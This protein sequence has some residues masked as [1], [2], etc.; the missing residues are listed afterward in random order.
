MKNLLLLPLLLLT[1]TACKIDLSII[2]LGEV[3]TDSETIDCASG[4][5]G[6]CQQEYVTDLADCDD[7]AN[8]TLVDTSTTETFTALPGD[9]SSFGGWGD[10]CFNAADLSCQHTITS[11]YA[12]DPD[13]QLNVTATFDLDPTPQDATYTYDVQD[14]TSVASA[15]MRRS[16]QPP[17]PACE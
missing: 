10:I 5:S 16:D 4:S 2:G 11:E 7:P 9:N 8:C 13:A 17:R 1:L 12:A 3:K 15:W 6:D 14:S